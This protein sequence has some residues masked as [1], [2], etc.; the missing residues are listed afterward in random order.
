MVWGL[1][2]GV[3]AVTWIPSFVHQS[4]ELAAGHAAANFC[5]SRICHS[6]A[7]GHGPFM[8]CTWFMQAASVCLDA[9]MCFALRQQGLA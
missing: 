5:Y 2:R 9:N 8:A 6:V 3:Q 1:L 4:V 7:H